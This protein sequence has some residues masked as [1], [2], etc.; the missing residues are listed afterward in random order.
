M[1]TIQPVLL[2]PA[3][4]KVAK[5]EAK[6]RE[7]F[8]EAFIPFITSH[9]I[10]ENS[11]GEITTQIRGLH[12]EIRTFRQDPANHGLKCHVTMQGLAE[13]LVERLSN[14]F[15]GICLIEKDTKGA[16]HP[17]ISWANCP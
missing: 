11:R 5:A 17:A 16:G 4:A 15:P 2:K 9:I 13:I 3:R 10:Y 14:V 1:P 8:L 6:D 7:L 12:D